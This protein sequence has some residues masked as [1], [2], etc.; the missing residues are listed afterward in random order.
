[1]GVPGSYKFLI[2]VNHHGMFST[3]SSFGWS[4]H[5]VLKADY[6]NT[7]AADALAPYITRPSAAMIYRSLSSMRTDLRYQYYV[8]KWQKMYCKTSNISHTLVGD[9]NFWSL[10]CSWS[11]ACQHCSN[12]TFILDL[13]PVFNGLGKDNNNNIGPEWHLFYVDGSLV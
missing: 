4:T 10:R 11:I 6:F 8:E 2:N 5:L 13:T 1:M 12:Y 9:Q 3:T 7:N